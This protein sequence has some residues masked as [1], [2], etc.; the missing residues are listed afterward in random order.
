MDF[1]QGRFAKIHDICMDFDHM[2]ERLRGLSKRFPSGLV[3][4]IIEKDLSSPTLARMVPEI[5]NCDYLTKVFIALSAEKHDAYEQATRLSHDFKI[6]CDVVWCNKPEVKAALEDLKKTGLDVT[7]LTG[8]GKDLW[9]TMGIASLELYAF[10]VHDADILYYSKMLPTKMLYPIIEPNLDFF[11]AKGYYARVN[12]EARRMYGRIYRLFVN[13]ILE[14]LQEK[15]ARPSRFL[16]YLQSFS[17]PLSGEFAIYS[18][19]ATHLRIPCDWGLEVGMLAELFRNASYRRICEVDLGLYDHKHKEVI[20]NG[21]LSTAEESLITLLRTLT[22]TD[23]IEV[24]TPFLKS[25]QVMYRRIAQDK[26]RQYH[27]DATCNGLDFDRH[28]EESWVDN[29]TTV[30]PSAGEKYLIDPAKTQLPDWLRAI[31][32][33]PNIRERLREEAIET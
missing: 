30:I 6:P 3:I 26:I 10:V 25:L 29:L 12:T 20:T 32:A 31:A 27:A 8:K 4:P 22:E 23:G 9:I 15:I 5:N 33:M 18:D 19:L 13:P 7:K 14:A 17:Y 28:E 11:F 21:L 2:S 24:T 1:S 16:T